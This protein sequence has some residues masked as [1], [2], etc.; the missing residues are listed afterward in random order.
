MDPLTQLTNPLDPVSID[1]NCT[2]L[3]QPLVMI[4]WST[5]GISNATQL[6]FPTGFRGPSV[7]QL[8]VVSSDLAGT[9]VFNCS[10]VIGGVQSIGSAI[11]N[12]YSK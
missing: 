3:S 9:H 11:I 4:S 6:Q 8:T 10:G 5:G 7:S 2:I 12:A 1:V